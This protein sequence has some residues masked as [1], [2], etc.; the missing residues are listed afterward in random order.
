[1][2]NGLRLSIEYKQRR[3]RIGFGSDAIAFGKALKEYKRQKRSLKQRAVSDN[4]WKRL[5]SELAAY[6]PAPTLQSER[7]KT[8]WDTVPLL[9]RISTVYRTGRVH[10]VVVCRHRGL[11]LHIENGIGDIT[12]CHMIMRRS[13][14][15]GDLVVGMTPVP[16]K[17]P[18]RY[19]G[20]GSRWPPVYHAA[21]NAAGGSRRVAWMAVATAVVS[22][23]H[24]HGDLPYGLR[25][26]C[27]YK[28]V[29]TKRQR[30]VLREKRRFKELPAP[31][32][33][34]PTVISTAYV[35][36][37]SDLTGAPFLPVSHNVMYRRINLGRDRICP[38][39]HAGYYNRLFDKA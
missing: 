13:V 30:L 29:G 36:F 10:L 18:P 14:A 25:S 23:E 21:I 26:T 8:R 37:P 2:K 27:V 3:V 11:D 15:P 5:V 6:A 12:L 9:R 31:G 35:R 38:T 22:E 1:M 32:R 28:L 33:N 4:E 34:G 24:Y 17:G 7:I 16:R 20:A 39:T 19:S